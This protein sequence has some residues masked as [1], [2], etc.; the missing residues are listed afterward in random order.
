M[1]PTSASSRDA[2]LL[3]RERSSGKRSLKPRGR[4]A[5]GGKSHH[6][7]SGGRTKGVWSKK[8]RTNGGNKQ[9]RMS[10]D[11]FRKWRSCQGRVKS[12]RPRHH[13]VKNNFLPK[14]GTVAVIRF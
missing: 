11:I 4:P 9:Q 6:K 5:G 12:D 14:S 8:N 10:E 2:L 3:E 1:C 7:I 13:G